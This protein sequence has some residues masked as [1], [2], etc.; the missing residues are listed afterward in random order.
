MWGCVIFGELCRFIRPWAATAF[1]DAKAG[2]YRCM[3]L[4]FKKSSLVSRVVGNK[5]YEFQ[6]TRQGSCPHRPLWA[7]ELFP[8]DKVSEGCRRRAM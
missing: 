5:L 7:L 1:P 6:G 8:S 4:L 2:P 3:V